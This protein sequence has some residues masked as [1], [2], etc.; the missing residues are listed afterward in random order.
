M[1]INKNLKLRVVYSIV[2]IGLSK[3]INIIFVITLITVCLCLNQSL[4]SILL[5]WIRFIARFYVN[6]AVAIVIFQSPVQGF[7]HWLMRNCS[8]HYVERMQLVMKCI[9]YLNVH[10]LK[11]KGINSSTKSFWVDMEFNFFS[12]F[13]EFQFYKCTQANRHVCWNYCVKFKDRAH[14]SSF[15]FF[16]FKKFSCFVVLVIFLVIV[17]SSELISVWFCEKITFFF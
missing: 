3:C 14:L 11:T 12:K 6:F 13:N 5:S 8:V 4:K 1:I 10:I 16:I 17:Q 15:K 9:I 7:I 2:N